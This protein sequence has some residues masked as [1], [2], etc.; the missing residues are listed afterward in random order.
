MEEKYNNF[1]K[2]TATTIIGVLLA[3]LTIFWEGFPFFIVVIIIALLG[4]KELY[5][6]ARKGGYRPS[7]IS[8][9]MLTLYFIIRVVY[10]FNCLN[11]YIENIIITFLII[12]T[13]IFQLFK[14]DYSKV[15]AEISITIFGSIY[16]GY[17]FSFMLKI[18]DLP[19]GNYFLISLLIITWANDIGAY[20]IGTIFGK[21]KIFPKISPKKTVEG[22]IGG[23]IV[24]IATTVALKNWLN[25]TINE[26]ISLG[27]IIAIAAQLG[28]LFESVLKRGSGI[29]D[30]GTLIP[31]QGGILD[32]VDSLIFT[33]PVFYY[34]I[35]S[36]LVS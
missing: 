32:C 31:G 23:T 30:S 4:L 20:L 27:L 2:R 34:Y 26:L 29:K 13:F 17:L 22:S 28:D 21:N 19:N 12:L 24:S 16:L 25:L 36:Y 7:Y 14:K 11:Y 3:F 10:D 15:L 35:I 5:S 1:L 6:I 9:S 18:K 33:A 8:G